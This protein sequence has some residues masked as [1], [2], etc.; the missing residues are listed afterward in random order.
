MFFLTNDFLWTIIVLSNVEKESSFEIWLANR[1]AI[2]GESSP[3]PIKMKDTLEFEKI[4]VVK[5]IWQVRW[6]R[7][8]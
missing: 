5:F 2:L 1:E 6:H 7:G 8:K 3:N 4:K